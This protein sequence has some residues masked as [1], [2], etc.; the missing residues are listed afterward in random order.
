[1]WREGA[2]SLLPTGGKI[3]GGKGIAGPRKGGEKEDEDEDEEEEEAGEK[4]EEEDEERGR[5]RRKINK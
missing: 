2:N 5:G 4:Q 3:K 1:M